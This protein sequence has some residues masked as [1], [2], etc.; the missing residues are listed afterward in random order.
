MDC[1]VR[2]HNTPFSAPEF[3]TSFSC[4][5]GRVKDVEVKY[6]HFSHSL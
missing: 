2:I 1:E 5:E 3:T 4:H 6:L